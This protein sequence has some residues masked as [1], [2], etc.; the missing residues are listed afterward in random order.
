MAARICTVEG[1]EKRHE[2]R[3]FCKAHWH[4]WRRYGDPLG[5]PH[6][7]AVSKQMRFYQNVVLTREGD[8]RLTWPYSLSH[9][10]Y[11][12]RVIQLEHRSIGKGRKARAKIRDRDGLLVILDVDVHSGKIMW[13]ARRGE[14]DGSRWNRRFSGKVAGGLNSQGYR[15]VNIAGAHHRAHLIVWTVAHGYWPCLDIDHIDGDRDNNRI[16]NL[17]EATRSENH[18]N[19]GVVRPERI[20]LVGVEKCGAKWLARIH[21]NGQAVYLGLF[22]TVDEA[23]SARRLAEARYGFD[24]MHGRRFA[25]GYG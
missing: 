23:K 25:H 9:D 1:C 4:R 20:G 24:P 18:R 10:G 14:P 12:K 16:Q 6:D 21:F 2:A 17:R 13:R 11:I 15:V 22:D 7:G 3:G 8:E 5:A 19:R